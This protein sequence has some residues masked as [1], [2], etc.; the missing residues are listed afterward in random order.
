MKIDLATV[1]YSEELN[2]L[3]TQ[4]RSIELYVPSENIGTIFVIINQESGSCDVD[5]S[6]YG[7]NSDKVKVINYRDWGFVNYN[8]HYSHR[9]GWQNQQLC[10]LLIAKE[11]DTE[12]YAVLDAKT[13]F[14]NPLDLSKLFTDNK[15]HAR[16]IKWHEHFSA[17][18]DSV[19]KQFSINM[20]ETIAPAG[21]PFFF[22]R[23]TVLDM[24]EYIE[25]VANPDEKFHDFFLLR[26]RVENP[27]YITEFCLYSG[28]IIFKHEHLGHLYHI[29]SVD[30]T[31]TPVNIDVYNIPEDIN[32]V[33]EL[34]D[35]MH[36]PKTVTA[37]VHRNTIARLSPR[38]LR[39]WLDFL[40][41]R[42]LVETQ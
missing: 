33:D 29:S 37:S 6:W 30:Y 14:V 39:R 12:W 4:A 20:I 8:E 21:V 24:I 28:Y 3:K 1:V 10:K 31:L 27:G 18:V 25:T 5:P 36:D 9:A 23:Q 34:L 22:H 41:E 16:L 42:N 40:E 19:N 13:W 7:V 26:S 11:S 17:S 15:Y 2:F 38:Q 32:R 35:S